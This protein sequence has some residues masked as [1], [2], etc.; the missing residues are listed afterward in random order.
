MCARYKIQ[1]PG[2]LVRSK[3]CD[4]FIERIGASAAAGTVKE[5]GILLKPGQT[6]SVDTRTMQLMLT[7]ADRPGDVLLWING[8]LKFEQATLVEIV[9]CLEKHFDVHFIISDAQLKKN[10]SPV[11]LVRMMISDKFFLY[12]LLPNVLIINVRIIT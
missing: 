12:L 9:Q 3:G 4:D 11:L 6:L 5:E 10:V 8:K 1:C 7:E 2:T